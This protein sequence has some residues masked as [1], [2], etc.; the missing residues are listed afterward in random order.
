[1]FSHNIK[2]SPSCRKRS[3]AGRAAGPMDVISSNWRMTW[4]IRVRC[5][6]V[7][8]PLR[9][10]I[11]SSLRYFNTSSGVPVDAPGIMTSARTSSTLPASAFACLS[12]FCSS[13]TTSSDRLLRISRLSSTTTFLL[14]D[15]TTNVIDAETTAVASMAAII[16]ITPYSYTTFYLVWLPCQWSA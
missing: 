8:L 11:G 6:S 15:E 3:M 16:F 7:S 12:C 4:R 2:S 14:V 10:P 5:S 9:S 13:A 1:M